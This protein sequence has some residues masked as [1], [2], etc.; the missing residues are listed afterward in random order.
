MP[1]K[2]G[3]KNP[4]GKLHSKWANSKIRIKFVKR[5]KPSST[6][7]T[8]HKEGNTSDSDKDNRDEDDELDQCIVWLANHVAPWET[9][10]DNWKK[11]SNLRIKSLKNNDKSLGKL[12]KDWPRYN[13]ELGY[14]LT[15]Y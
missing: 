15:F 14:S 13:D 3:S 12:L 9:V 10:L 5:T 8:S 4:T 1:R 7:S 6:T 2:Q 11:T